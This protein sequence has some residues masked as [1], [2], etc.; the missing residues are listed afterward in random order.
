MSCLADRAPAAISELHD[1]ELAMIAFL[2]AVHGIV[3][4]M[5]RDNHP[6]AATLKAEWKKAVT[7]HGE[8]ESGA[9]EGT[10]RHG[11]SGLGES[12]RIL[13]DSGSAPGGKTVEWCHVGQSAGCSV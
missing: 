4:K 6:L 3:A 7:G 11:L 8:L 10:Q 13:L 1:Y 2:K 9:V 12:A 5:E